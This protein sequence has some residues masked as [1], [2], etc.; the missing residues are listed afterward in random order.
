MSRYRL[1]EEEILVAV[2]D[3]A[4]MGFRTVVLQSGEDLHYASREIGR[5]IERIKSKY[6]LAV[7]LSLGERRREDYQLWRQAGAD[8]YLL[9]HETA[10]ARL[11]QHLKPDSNLKRRLQCIYWL[12]EL[13]Y[14]T[15]MGN[16]V[17]LPG[18]DLNILAEDIMLMRQ[19]EAE[20]AGIGPFLPHPATPLKNAA[21]GS[22]E[23]CLKTL[24][25]A[26]LCIPYAHLP[27]TTALRTLTPG[28]D[29]LALNCGA[30]VIM[31][32]MTPLQVRSKYLIY[33]QKADIVDRPEAALKQIKTLLA[34]TGRSPAQNYGHALKI[35]GGN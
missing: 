2:A 27:A 20:M 29:R 6:D 1:T 35:G 3:A 33:P 23:L 17:G 8:R 30:N 34:E 28:G 4:A 25:V 10:A 24:A 21:A 11:F 32:N 15:G 26:R 9:K 18:Q 19:F 16:M 5:L 14:Q 31:P 12:K 22:L 13:G 7:T